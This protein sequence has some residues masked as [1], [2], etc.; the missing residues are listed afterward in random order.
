MEQTTETPATPDPVP[1]PAAEPDFDAWMTTQGKAEVPASEPLPP[2]ESTEPAPPAEATATDEPAPPAEE[3]DPDPASE[4]GRTLAKHKRSLQ[5]RIDQA[6]AK[7]RE[8]ERRAEALQQEIAA[9]KAMPSTTASGTST[10]PSTVGDTYVTPA[11]DPEPTLEQFQDQDDPYLA[12]AKAA[13]RWAARDETRKQKFDEAHATAAARARIDAEAAAR[14]TEQVVA[15][16]TRRLDAFRATHPDFDARLASSTAV[17]TPAIS[18]AIAH[19]E[20]G[21]QIVHYFLD[22]PEESHRIAALPEGRQRYEIGRLAARFDAAP[23]SGPA[24]SVPA[25]SQ[26]PPPPK[27]VGASA[28]TLARDLSQASTDE[29]IESMNAE[30]KRRRR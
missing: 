2:A 3:P 8:A 20:Q 15:D 27:P 19:S 6:T 1:P 24:P 22:H 25:I 7:Q 21:P 5:A 29:Y 4:A 9:L 30:E 13:A 11:D 28:T 23:S 12:H 16:H 18:E 26:A 10:P 14:Q 17:T